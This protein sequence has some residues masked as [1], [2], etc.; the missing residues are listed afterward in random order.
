[1]LIEYSRKVVDNEKEQYIIFSIGM[2]DC[3]DNS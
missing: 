1:M 3:R 2:S